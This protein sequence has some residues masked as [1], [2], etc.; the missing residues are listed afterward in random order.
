MQQMETKLDLQNQVTP[1]KHDFTSSER[2]LIDGH[3]VTVVNY[4]G[5][6]SRSVNLKSVT[7]KFGLLW[8][9]SEKSVIP[10]DQHKISVKKTKTFVPVTPL[11]KQEI[12]RH[13]TVFRPILVTQGKSAKDI[14]PVK[15]SDLQHANT[16]VR[17][18]ESDWFLQC[19]LKQVDV[20]K[21]K[22]KWQIIHGSLAPDGGWVTKRMSWKQLESAY[23]ACDLNDALFVQGTGKPMTDFGKA[24]RTITSTYTDITVGENMLRK[25]ITTEA[26]DNNQDGWLDI[27]N[28]A[29]EHSA[30]VSLEHYQTRKDDQATSKFVSGYSISMVNTCVLWMHNMC[31]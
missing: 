8:S 9:S 30:S 28:E 15:L 19:H 22:R 20:T 10:I 23:L 6:P 26:A 3:L 5:K 12:I 27:T 24:L 14:K 29:L 2:N 16:M 25:I 17:L 4:D 7:T 21:K 11:I 31:V 1:G 18:N 13:L